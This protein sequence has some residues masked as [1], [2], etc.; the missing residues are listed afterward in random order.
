MTYLVAAFIAIPLTM[1]GIIGIL[2]ARQR[3]KRF[4]ETVD[5]RQ[6]AEL[7]DIG[8]APL[9]DCYHE[10]RFTQS[11]LALSKVRSPERD[12]SPAPELAESSSLVLAHRAQSKIPDRA[13]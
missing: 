8:A 4:F 13:A 5:E 6:V 3:I 9:P 1:L 2:E 10:L 7:A 11:L 12:G